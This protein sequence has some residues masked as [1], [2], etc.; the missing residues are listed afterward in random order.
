MAVH[1]MHEKLHFI[2]FQCHG[3]R[4]LKVTRKD[5][6]RVSESRESSCLGKSS[7]TK[8]PEELRNTM[9]DN[10]AP[11]LLFDSNCIGLERKA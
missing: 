4:V 8:A 3:A 11:C 9:F 7:T 2:S 6:A 5:M 10:P 1:K